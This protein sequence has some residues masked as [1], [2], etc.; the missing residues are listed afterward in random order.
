MVLIFLALF[1]VGCSA[2]ESS[3]NNDTEMRDPI[4]QLS[5]YLT[6]KDQTEGITLNF[7]TKLKDFVEKEK[8]FVEKSIEYQERIAQIEQ[9]ELQWEKE[10]RTEYN[11]FLTEYTLHLSQY[12]FESDQDTENKIATFTNAYMQSAR[13][14]NV[15]MTDYIDTLSLD[16]LEKY[17]QRNSEA[18]TRL[19]EVIYIFAE[20]SS[21]PTK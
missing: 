11:D 14:R 9:S 20:D 8:T 19:Y 16:K 21:K 7:R 1:V 15:H 13:G 3:E 6:E 4:F 12:H 10:L 17:N 5:E 2:T 18:Q